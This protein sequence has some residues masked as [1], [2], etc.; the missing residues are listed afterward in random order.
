MQLKRI[1]VITAV[2]CVTL[3]GFINLL[4]AVS[5]A[6]QAA[7][8]LYDSSLGSTPSGQSFSYLALN[9]QP[10]FTTQATQIYSAPV[11]IL[12]TAN[13]LNDYAGYTVNQSAMPTLDRAAGFQLAFDLRL[14]SE[15]HSGNN[16]RAG[17]SVILLDQDVYGIEMAFW[18]NEIWVQEGNGGTPIF[19]HAEGV[20]YNSTNMLTSYKLTV[21]SNTY[22]LAANGTPLL[23]GNL[24]QYTSWEPP[25]GPLPDP[26]EQP[27]QLFLGDDTSSAGAE[28]WLG[29]VSIETNIAPMISVAQTA[30]SLP[31]AITQTTFIINLNTPSPITAT[32]QYNLVGGTAVASEDFVANS[33]TLTFTPGSLSQNIQISLLPDAL[34]EPDETFSLQLFNGVNGVLGVDTA[35]VTI[36]DDDLPNYDLYLPL[37]TRP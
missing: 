13:Q 33:G 9:P 29:N 35:V 4:H 17:F 20:L 27:N 10:P 15:N 25:V 19:S 21:I 14:I 26:Y 7:T 24:R 32:V 11:T 22:L 1:A 16:D 6:P 34:P 37:L 8:L 12:N 36:Q 30:V 28:V 3:S 2:F 23:S 18:E 31:E 5:A